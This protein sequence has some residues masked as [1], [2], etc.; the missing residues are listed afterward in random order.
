MSPEEGGKAKAGVGSLSFRASPA[1]EVCADTAPA[2]G[3]GHLGCWGR[4]SGSQ[5]EKDT[6]CAGAGTQERT[7]SR[8]TGRGGGPAVPPGGLN[9][10]QTPGLLGKT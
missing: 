7:S 5:G 2:R 3:C 10:R 4:V 9:E 6:A 1:H 8:N